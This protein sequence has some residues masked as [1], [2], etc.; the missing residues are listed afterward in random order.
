MM[1][2]RS[3]NSAASQVN[4]L[5][6]EI[7]AL[8]QAHELLL[9]SRRMLSTL[10]NNLPGMVYRCAND[11]QWTIE[12]MSRGTHELLGF[13]P[14]RLMGDTLYNFMALVHPEDKS[15]NLIAIKKALEK[16]ESYELIYR[17]RT[18]S[19][20]AGWKWVW[21]RGEGIFSDDGQLLALEGFVTDISDQKIAE[22]KLKNENTLLRSSIIE[23]F[24]FGDI[25]GKSP[26]MQRVYDLILKA[27]TGNANVVIYGESGTGK[28]LVA[29]AI[30]DA[31]DRQHQAFVP[32]NCGAIPETLM[33]SEFFGHTK[34]A[35]SGAYTDKTGYLDMADKGTLFL[36]ELGEIS[37][38][39][40]VKLLRVLDGMGYMPLGGRTLKRP[41]FRIIAATN[42]D[43]KSL[44]A[45]GK[46]REDFYYRIH[47]IPVHL[48]P[49]RERKE[50]IPLLVDHFVQQYGPDKGYQVFPPK[51][52]T[53][54]EKYDWPGNVRELRNIVDQYMTVGETDLPEALA[55]DAPDRLVLIRKIPAEG[56][57]DFRRAVADFEKQ[58]ILNMLERCRWRK[59]ESASLM[60]ITPRTLQRKLKQYKLT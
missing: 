59:G 12:F 57:T 35:F 1:K 43:V 8:R 18:K 34:G 39:L 58:F 37:L 13:P 40:Q 26:G 28:E 42:R 31:G 27:A 7:L 24:K 2:N 25:I 10:M 52:R 19:D 36:D 53:A 44:M 41:D 29:R 32:V 38:E 54:F 11:D 56:D 15:N 23:R 21:D 30:H 9:E 49:L 46:M 5:K 45:Q 60:G 17:I 47:V 55:R 33:E 22:I 51:L 48:P 4:Q 6:K 14:E 50:D 20:P 3:H 16:K